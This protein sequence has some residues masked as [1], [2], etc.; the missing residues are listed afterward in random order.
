MCA[1]SPKTPKVEKIPD[2]QP[3][4]MPDG[5]D[6]LVRASMRGSGKL[7]TSAMIFANRSGSL[8]APSVATPLGT[9]GM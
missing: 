1:P 3:L 9:R 4:L 2:R 7:R 6:P 5:G 8:G